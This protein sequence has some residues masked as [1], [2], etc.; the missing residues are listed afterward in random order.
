V[1][2]IKYN[3]EGAETRKQAKPGTYLTKIDA[4]NHR[5]EKGDI[6]VIVQ[7]Q[8]G[9]FKNSKLW[10][11]LNFGEASAWKLREFTDALGLKPKGTLDTDKLKGKSI[12]VVVAADTW[13]GE[14]RA[15]I[16]KWLDPEA[17]E[18]DE[19]EDEDEGEDLDDEDD[20]DEDDEDEESEDGDYSSLNLKE[21]LAAAKDRGLKL[22]AKQKKDRD[23]LIELLEEADEGEDEDEDDEEEDEPEPPKKGKAKAKPLGKKA[24]PVVEE[25]DD[26]EDEDEGEDEDD[27]D[28]DEEGDDEEP[29]D[30]NEWEEDDLQEELESRGLKKTGSK[31]QMVKRLEQDD[32]KSG[33]KPF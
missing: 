11:Y 18:A 4:M 1:A 5:E 24:A 17:M 10:S 8:D 21:L 23:A 30:Y 12:G 19:D 33:T 26:D 13:N 31:K 32:A 25:E 20:D 27:D 16:N 9:E 6:E 2:K 28:E 22:T 29:E 3:V 14:Y 15:R 7:I